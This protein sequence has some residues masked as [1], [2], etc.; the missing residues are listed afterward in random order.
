N[1]AVLLAQAGRRVALVDGDLRHP[2]LHEFFGIQNDVG[3][4]SVMIGDAAL[5]PALQPVPGVERLFLLPSGPVP[6]NPAELLASSRCND[7]L[8]T[9][10]SQYDIVL[11]D[12]PPVL[13]V[14]DA[15]VL[16]TRS[17]A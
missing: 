14:T 3:F 8:A 10:K 6:P 12:S 2:R 7:V 13:P 17:D 11:I 1:L 9:L 16:A 15:A 4:T 5:D